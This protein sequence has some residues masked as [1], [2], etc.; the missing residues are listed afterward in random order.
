MTEIISI[1]S[2]K[3]GVGKT[4]LTSNLADGLSKENKSVLVVDANISGANLGIHM[5]MLDPGIDL[6]SVLA[7]K[8]ELTDAVY[9]HANGFHVLP[10]ALNVAG[11][12]MRGFKSIISSLVGNYD[13]I[14]ID[15]AAGADSEV[16]EAISASDS[17]LI[18]TNPDIP[19]VSNAALVKRLASNLG[20]P[21]KGII[22]NM[23]RGEYL[24]LS[25]VEIS[26]FLGENIISKIP[27][28]KDVKQSIV[29]GK[30]VLDYNRNSP[31]S[32]EISSLSRKLCGVEDKK[33][34]FFMALV[35]RIPGLNR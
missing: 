26:K 4:T 20:K 25:D 3:G 30:S 19:S 9:R 22:L 13:F 2:G 8:S 11:E 27:Y 21:I 18:V 29:L 35:S 23:S 24:E 16:K 28:H 33:D 12:N 14:L 31:P 6:N 15:T 7:G 32:V 1:V 5:N 34:N 10:A 17:V